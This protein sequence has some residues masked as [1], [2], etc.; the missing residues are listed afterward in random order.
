MG[1]KE[2]GISIEYFTNR[3]YFGVAI[4]VVIVEFG[5]IQG[6]YYCVQ[7]MEF[8]SV[9]IGKQI[10]LEGYSVLKFSIIDNLVEL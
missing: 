6:I 4:A 5:N 8:L 10:A 7:A 1:S 9:E 2:I 3:A